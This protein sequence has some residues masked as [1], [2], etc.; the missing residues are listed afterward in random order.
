MRHG[1]LEQRLGTLMDEWY[2]VRLKE[3]EMMIT[4][5]GTID[6]LVD[7]LPFIEEKWR[8]EY[9][10]LNYGHAVLNAQSDHAIRHY[11]EML[12]KLYKFTERQLYFA[13]FFKGTEAFSQGKLLQALKHYKEALRLLKYVPRVVEEGEI[14]F[15]IA[16]V[17]YKI[18][19]YHTANRFLHRAL[20]IY[21]GE[22]GYPERVDACKLL[23]SLIRRK[24]N[25]KWQWGCASL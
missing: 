18:G 17:Y 16:C 15:K 24:P 3:P 7:R 19:A 6:A 14:Y 11:Y 22:R 9:T 13:S 8:M 4:V 23:F 20:F 2:D 1:M 25:P 5:K 21:S 10:I 12:P